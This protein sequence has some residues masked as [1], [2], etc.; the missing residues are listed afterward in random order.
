MA[1][2][3]W[4][5]DTPT[6]RARTLIFLLRQNSNGEQEILLGLK[7]VR[8]GAGKVGG[9]GGKLDAGETILQAA[10][11]EMPEESS[12]L[13]NT[14]DL[15]HVAHL[16]FK[17]PHRPSWSQTAYVFCATHWTGTPQESEEIRPLWVPLSQ[18]PYE[19]MWPDAAVW[20][21]KILAGNKIAAEF[22]YG[23]D[24]ATLSDSKIN[25]I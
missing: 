12:V 2:N 6:P 16:D 14:A 23:A 9:I 4:D 17:F 7:K 8:F 18:I 15:N 1:H 25:S 22:I 20:L 13:L 21:P 24:N 3:I 5:L 19:K 11:R 10:V